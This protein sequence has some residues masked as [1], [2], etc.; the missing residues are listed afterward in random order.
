MPRARRWTCVRKYILRPHF[1]ST[2][3]PKTSVDESL[4]GRPDATWIGEACRP[5]LSDLSVRSLVRP[6]PN[7]HSM[8][9]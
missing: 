6:P 4:V 1:G 5:S 8:W 7:R 3:L 2:V 9:L